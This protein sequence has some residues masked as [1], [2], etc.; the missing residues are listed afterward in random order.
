MITVNGNTVTVSTKTLDAVLESGALVSLRNKAGREFLPGASADSPALDI[1][2]RGGDVRAVKGCPQG[3]V[4]C[5]S[6]S[7]T[8][9]EIR[10]DALDGNGVRVLARISGEARDVTRGPARRI[11]PAGRSVMMAMTAPTLRC[12]IRR[13]WRRAWPCWLPPPAR[14]P[15]SA[16]GFPTPPPSR[17]GR[18][19]AT[20]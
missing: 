8:C 20:A 19:A 4:T 10:F 13:P 9:A 1:V 2:F 3:R 6:L 5:T 14:W 18:I 7:D 12:S 16:T 15:P 17:R 11:S